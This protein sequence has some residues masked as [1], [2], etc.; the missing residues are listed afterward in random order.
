MVKG[1]FNTPSPDISHNDEIRH[2]RDSF[3]NTQESLTSY[4]EQLKTTT[5]AKASMESELSIASRIQ[6]SMLPTKFP[7]RHDVSIFGKLN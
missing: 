2:L 4:N 7:E 6:M 5:A 1:N 3:G